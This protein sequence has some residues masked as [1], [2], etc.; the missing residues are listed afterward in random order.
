MALVE[1]CPADAAS[2]YC[3]GRTELAAVLGSIRAAGGLSAASGGRCAWRSGSSS[4]GAC[5]PLPLVHDG[6]RRLL[7]QL[8]TVSRDLGLGEISAVDPRAAGAADISFVASDVKMAID[9]L[10]LKGTADHTVGETADLR[11]LPVQIKR[12]AV[13]LHRLAQAR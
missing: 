8:S 7:A 4:A 10:G 6:N 1:G 3:A 11:L 9:A 5:W 2:W 13:L 12:S